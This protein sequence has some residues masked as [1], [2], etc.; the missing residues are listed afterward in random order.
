MRFEPGI[1]GKRLVA[2][3]ALLAAGGCAMQG[4]PEQR[5]R[6]AGESGVTAGTSAS[7]ESRRE[8][9]QSTAGAQDARSDEPPAP[10]PAER[11]VIDE[12]LAERRRGDYPEI[13]VQESGFT[14]TEQARIGNA[15]RTDYERAIDLLR[16]E[17]HVEGIALLEQVV[18]TTPDVTAPYI[19]LGI[20]YRATG[21]PEE[22]E[23]A[24]N[25]A[26]LLSPD[27]PIVLNELGILYRG[28]GRFG[29]ARAS[30]EKALEVFGDFH[31]A[32][33]N[34]AVLCDLY[35]ADLQ[36]A[37]TNYRAYLDSAGSDAEVE[38]WVAD[39][40]NRLGN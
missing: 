30:Y 38:I 18:E 40:E 17:R 20:A 26:R 27:N 32:R 35:L 28:T 12:I 14:I 36:C 3:V 39:I 33:R 23:Q 13:E 11:S 25:T 31:F 34:L 19:D 22:A 29:E 5:A 37:L 16:Q 8:A 1:N 10:V 15:A 9:Q 21:K 4:A 7:R 6:S 2:L 24:L